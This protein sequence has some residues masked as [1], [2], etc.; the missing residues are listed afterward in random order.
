MS[1]WKETAHQEW[2]F[3]I[4]GALKEMV[5][6][7]RYR[8]IKAEVETA[9]DEITEITAWDNNIMKPFCIGSGGNKCID[10]LDFFFLYFRRALVHPLRDSTPEGGVQPNISEPRLKKP[11]FILT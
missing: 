3:A 2:A 8:L 11:V 9:F 5:H 6:F 4:E 7:P 1:L 10:G